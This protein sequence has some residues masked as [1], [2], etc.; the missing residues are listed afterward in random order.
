MAKNI[1]IE[2]LRRSIENAL[3]F[4]L[5]Q[6]AAQVGFARVIT[7]YTTFAYLCDVYVLPA[8]RKRGLARWLM[9]CV[10]AH[11]ELQGLRRWCLFTHDAHEL[12]KEFDFSLLENPERAMEK[13]VVRRYA[14]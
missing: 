3:G 12:Y 1:P 5:L 14:P 10:L 7:D 2:T 9:Q 11:P 13:R 6:G 4:A 8:H